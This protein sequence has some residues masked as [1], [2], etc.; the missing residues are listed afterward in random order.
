ML[1]RHLEEEKVDHSNPWSAWIALEKGLLALD[2]D[3]Y[4]EALDSSRQ[5]A[6]LA[7]QH[8]DWE[9][10]AEAHALAGIALRYLWRPTSAIRHLQA[11]A[12]QARPHQPL[13]ARVLIHLAH[14]QLDAGLYRPALDIY[15]SIRAHVH[16][17]PLAESVPEG[18]AFALERLG[19][20]DT[21]LQ[22]H[23]VILR[24]YEAD[25][26]PRSIAR[27]L[28]N[29]GLCHKR[30]D[31]WR[32]ARSF[33]QESLQVQTDG[34]DAACTLEELAQSAVLADRREQ[35]M[36]YVDRAESFVAPFP[37]HP[38]RATLTLLREGILGAD[39][40]GPFPEWSRLLASADPELRSLWIQG[41]AEA[42]LYLCWRA[43][44]NE[45]LAALNEFA[46]GMLASGPP[47]LGTS[48]PP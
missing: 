31:D 45:A 35:A 29:M 6:V 37:R 39:R 4:E 36:E 32:E 1:V 12:R 18:K 20:P 48:P 9:C 44:L 34:F 11:A 46:V 41:S 47:E 43:P 8:S 28:N 40:T 17:P 27:V 42:A 24:R 33:W 7:N 23:R 13:H 10:Q 16:E 22:V 5:A 14:A 2:Q 26:E 30:M 21:A 19:Q 25:G 15:E 3:R 38:S